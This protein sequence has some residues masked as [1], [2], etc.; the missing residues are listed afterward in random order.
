M[1]LSKSPLVPAVRFSAQCVPLS[2][3]VQPVA[4]RTQRLPVADVSVS[5]LTSS[6]LSDL[7]YFLFVP[8]TLFTVR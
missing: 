7:L 5:T 1:R 3:E 8:G 6:A 2:L 4:V